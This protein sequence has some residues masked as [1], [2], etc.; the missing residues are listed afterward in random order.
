MPHAM[1]QNTLTKH[2]TALHSAAMQMARESIQAVGE[3][4]QLKMLIDSP[5][6]ASSSD[7]LDI[8]ESVNGISQVILLCMENFQLS[9]C[10]WK[11][12]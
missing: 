2:L 8:D 6:L 9:S 12:T 10:K 11:N 3:E 4:K 7:P 1:A 5:E